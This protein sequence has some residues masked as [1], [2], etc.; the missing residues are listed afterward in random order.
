M[1]GRTPSGEMGSTAGTAAAALHQ[2]AAR[3]ASAAAQPAWP[4]SLDSCCGVFEDPPQLHAGLWSESDHAR[5]SVAGK[6]PQPQCVRAPRGWL[7]AKG[8]CVF[9]AACCQRAASR[10]WHTVPSCG[11]HVEMTRADMYFKWCASRMKHGACPTGPVIAC[12]VH[13]ACT[14]LLW[15][16]IYIYI[17]VAAALHRRRDR[18]R[19]VG[20]FH[21]ELRWRKCRNSHGAQGK[22]VPRCR[23]PEGSA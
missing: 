17:G 6:G 22:A 18:V 4:Q 9:N 7:T 12:T 16:N 21:K 11:K 8:A 2:A 10:R 1:R 3:S 14:V 13:A 5:A 19:T 15:L 23:C 20:N